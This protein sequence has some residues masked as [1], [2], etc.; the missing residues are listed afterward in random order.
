[1]PDHVWHPVFVPATEDAARV[2]MAFWHRAPEGPAIP[3]LRM[4]DVTFE[5]WGP[6]PSGL[7]PPYE[8][9][10]FFADSFAVA[11]ALPSS[12]PGFSTLFYVPTGSFPSDMA[13]ANAAPQTDYSP[14]PPPIAQWDAFEPGWA[15][16]LARG[17]KGHLALYQGDG[18]Y[19]YLSVARVSPGELVNIYGVACA[20]APFPADTVPA[21]GGFLVAS[22]SGGDFN[23][24]LLDDGIPGPARRLLVSRFDLDADHLV[25]AASFEEPDPIAHVAMAKANDGAWVVWQNDGSSALQPPPIRAVRLDE[26]GAQIGPVFN[27]THDGQTSGPFA[28]ASLGVWLAVAWVDAIDPS[29]PTLRVDLFGPQGTFLSGTSLNTSP[30]WLHDPALALMASPNGQHLL[31]AWSDIDVGSSTPAST[32]VARF[33]CGALP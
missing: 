26:S 25:P 32:R 1:M 18:P 20:D 8:V 17:T 22:A 15:V 2:S 31:L 27:V 14:F 21:Q 5:P 4:G 11:P 7:G 12:Q 13:L 28:V 16:A 29:F 3:P 30:N 9:L 19:A 33:S 10:E 6:W 23:A 24:C